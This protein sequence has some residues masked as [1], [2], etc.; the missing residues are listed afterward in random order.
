MPKKYFC[1]ECQRDHASGKI[2]E[3][4]KKYASGGR[5]GGTFTKKFIV[6]YEFWGEIEIEAIDKYVAMNKVEKLPR[7]QLIA[8]LG[9]FIEK[10]DLSNIHEK[11]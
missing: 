10:I 4:H 5:T 3:E 1:S 11:K 9:K 2:Y 6:H 7:K 8:G